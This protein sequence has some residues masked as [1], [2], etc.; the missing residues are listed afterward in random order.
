MVLSDRSPGATYA[1]GKQDLLNRA[2]ELKDVGNVE[3]GQGRWQ[4]AI[5][6]YREGLAE[7][8]DTRAHGRSV[9]V[10]GKE[11]E[12]QT[13]QDDKASLQLEMSEEDRAEW[14]ECREL[15][16]MLSAN[17]AACYLKLV[18]YPFG[19]SLAL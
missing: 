2:K 14:E 6:S 4:M 12:L 8:P 13:D 1:V 18:S 15:H 9:S 10:K 3:F 5:E 11:K 16:A 17:V 7:L 19:A